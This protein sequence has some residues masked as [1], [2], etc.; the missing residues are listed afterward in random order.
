MS[1][2]LVVD[3]DPAVRTEMQS[4]VSSRGFE[5]FS[6]STGKDGLA[7]FYAD[8]PD[9]VLMEKDFTESDVDG[10]TLC[11]QLRNHHA[12]GGGQ[13]PVLFVARR[14]ELPERIAAFESGADDFVQKPTAVEE[15]F[16]RVQALLRRAKGTRVDILTASDLLIDRVRHRVTR[17]GEEIPLTLTEYKLLEYLVR[18]KNVALTRKAILDA[19]WGGTADGFTNIVDVYI[20]YLRRKL[21]RPEETMK[22]IKTVRGVGYLLEG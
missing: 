15:I 11:R 22:L 14:A 18:N 21:E 2:I 9:A 8:R 7:R 17:A 6:A 13:V 3:E 20:N 1:K 12:D 16:A 4:Y 10:L 19:V 5:V